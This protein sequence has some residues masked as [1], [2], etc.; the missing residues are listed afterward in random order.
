MVVRPGRV[1]FLMS[2][3]GDSLCRAVSSGGVCNVC[4]RLFD[5][6]ELCEPRQLSGQPKGRNEV[7]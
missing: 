5:P 4:E 3:D 1:L 6:P 2:V 7:S